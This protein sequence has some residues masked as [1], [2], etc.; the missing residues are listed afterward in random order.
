MTRQ[1]LFV[2]GGGKGTHDE[3]DD[4]LVD[5]LARALGARYEVRYPRMP[6]EADP[7]CASWMAAL[8]EQIPALDDGAILVGHSIGGTI[9][10]AAL[11]EQ[12]PQRKLGAVF[13]IA[14]PYVGQDGWPSDDIAQMT[15]L[16]LRLPKGLPIYLYH[17]DADE[18]VPF[19]HLGFY[20]TAIP[21]AVVRPLKGRN[22]QLN[23]NMSEV[24]RDIKELRLQ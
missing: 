5:S 2:Q 19:S 21:R 9:L 18:S 15:G 10:I 14:A 4:K 3:W 12:K 7:N 1:I 16:G 17:G 11:A 24:A 8:I 22:H 20:A 13:L 6:N 23:D